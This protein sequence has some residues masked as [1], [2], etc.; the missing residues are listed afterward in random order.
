MT[1]PN[2]AEAKRAAVMAIDRLGESDIVSVVAYGDTADV[3]AAVRRLSDA[4][5]I[6]NASRGSLEPGGAAVGIPQA[7]DAEFADRAV[8]GILV[9]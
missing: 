5:E 9:Q 4:G 6:R 2:L 7:P 1:G 8:G 3:L